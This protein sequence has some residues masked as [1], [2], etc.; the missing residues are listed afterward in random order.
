MLAGRM[1]I[2]LG[3]EE[4]VL[5]PGEVIEFDTRVPHRFGRADHGLVEFLSIVGPRASVS[6]R[7]TRV[8]RRPP[9]SRA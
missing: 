4:L 7:W 2:V 9:G 6:G 8:R 3:A 5:G 1:R